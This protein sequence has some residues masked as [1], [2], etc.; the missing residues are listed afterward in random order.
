M[1]DLKAKD[2]KKAWHYE[3]AKRSKR[4]QDKERRLQKRNRREDLLQNT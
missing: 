2:Y 4:K 3:E 1:K